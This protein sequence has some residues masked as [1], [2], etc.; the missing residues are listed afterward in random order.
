MER[1]NLC[2]HEAY[3]TTQTKQINKYIYKDTYGGPPV[4][5]LVYSQEEEKAQNHGKGLEEMRSETG[6]ML[7]QAK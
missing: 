6:V 2:N 5:K 4:Q 3:A 7:P 1:H